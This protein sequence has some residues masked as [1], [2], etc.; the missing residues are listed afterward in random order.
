MH[1]F[2]DPRAVISTVMHSGT[3][4]N[5][6]SIE[7]MTAFAQTL[8]SR[9]E[10]DYTTGLRLTEMYPKQFKMVLYEDFLVRIKACDAIC[11]IT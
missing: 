3:F 10:Q 6:D 4:Q 11:N 7:R 9:M 2:R 5:M 8:C 1:V